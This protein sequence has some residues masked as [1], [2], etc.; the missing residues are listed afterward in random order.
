MHILRCEL[1]A[2]QETFARMERA[3]TR[4]LEQTTAL[5][6]EK[7]RSVSSDSRRHS[8]QLTSLAKA[9]RREKQRRLA[10][11]NEVGAKSVLGY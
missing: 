10:S 8:V 5:E 6:A 4:T 9:M 11:R 1:E 2:L 7:A 3:V